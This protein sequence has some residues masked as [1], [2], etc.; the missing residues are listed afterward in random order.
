MAMIAARMVPAESI[1][2]DSGDH[3]DERRPRTTPAELR[4]GRSRYLPC[5]SGHALP[6]SSS[7]LRIEGCRSARCSA[8]A[9][10]RR[11]SS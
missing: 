9:I 8:A 7:R 5:E 2:F 10:R 3:P 6:R 11:T 1:S 4:G